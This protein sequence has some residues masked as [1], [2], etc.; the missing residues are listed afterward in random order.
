MR[1]YTTMMASGIAAAVAIAVLLAGYGFQ[2]S[3]ASAEA[4]KMRPTPVKA[5]EYLEFTGFRKF[6][7]ATAAYVNPQLYKSA[8]VTYTYDFSV[9]MGSSLV[10]KRSFDDLAG[11]LQSGIVW[12][13]V[14]SVAGDVFEVV[15]ATE[16]DWDE[17]TA[18]DGI[19]A[20]VTEQQVQ[21]WIDHLTAMGFKVKWVSKSDDFLG[22]KPT[23][24]LISWDPKEPVALPIANPKLP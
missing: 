11:A 4:E 21:D 18:Q 22:M 5:G 10:E 3:P 2:L 1:L 9:V 6:K 15:P 14:A 20:E 13:A 12:P 17:Y 7:L 19:A 8:E 23:G 24:A 16:L